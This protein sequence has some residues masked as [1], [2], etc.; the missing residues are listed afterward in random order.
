[1][2]CQ[3]LPLL[4]VSCVS[5]ESS[6]PFSSFKNTKLTTKTLNYT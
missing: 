2:V 1:M 3:L 4:L 5:D 6:I